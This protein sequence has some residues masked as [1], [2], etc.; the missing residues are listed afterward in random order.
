MPAEGTQIQQ[1]VAL[2]W[3]KRGSSEGLASKL[4]LTVHGPQKTKTGKEL[5]HFPYLEEERRGGAV[6]GQP[7]MASRC[8]SS[9]EVV[10]FA[11]PRGCLQ[12]V[13]SLPLGS[14][15]P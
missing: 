12:S 1:D 3:T 11:W 10:V 8:P 14:S 15:Y 9:V 2:K 4:G 5:S 7:S 6:M 13:L